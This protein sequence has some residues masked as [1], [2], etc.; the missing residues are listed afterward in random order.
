MSSGLGVFVRFIVNIAWHLR[1][2][3]NRSG[4]LWVWKFIYLKRGIFTRKGNLILYIFYKFFDYLTVFKSERFS[5]RPCMS[6]EIDYDDS[7]CSLR[8][9]TSRR[10]TEIDLA[11]FESINKSKKK[12]AYM[13]SS[14]SSIGSDDWSRLHRYGTK[15]ILHYFWYFNLKICY[16]LV[17]D[18][19]ENRY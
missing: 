6:S 4:E 5:I 12:L 13:H 9:H 1:D 10:F 8:G 16:F 15:I 3:R 2:W 7:D 14:G 17:S 18:C 19:K 11:L